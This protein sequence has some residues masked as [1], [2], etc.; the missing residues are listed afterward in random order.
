MN[1][2]KTAKLEN[3]DR[4]QELNPEATLKRAGFKENMTLCDIGAGT[5]I[6]SFP[7]A[8]MS[9]NDIYALEASDS[10]LELL[11]ERKTESKVENLQIRKVDSPVLPLADSICDMALLV[12]VLHEIEDKPMM[13]EEIRRVL[14][15]KGKLL[16]IEF[17]KRS[18][19]MGPPV[20]HRIAQ[21]DAA[22]LSGEKG[23]ATV[24][25]FSLG[26][27]FYGIVLE[28][29]KEGSMKELQYSITIQAPREKV[30]ATLWEDESFRDWAGLIDEGTYMEGPME[31]GKEVRFISSVNGYG[32]TSL[33]DELRLYE[34]IS[35]RHS[36]D[37]K[38]RGQQER[39]KEWTGGRESYSLTEKD[40]TTLLTVKTDV[41]Q[42]LI[43]IFNIRLPLALDRIRT[44]A[45]SRNR[46]SFK[47]A[48]MQ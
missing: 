12:T 36:T 11:Q 48:P 2:H 22:E 4:V 47:I 23:F 31:E 26:G 32:V 44:L 9:S 19:P 25:E 35:F 6:F 42:E 18:T 41:P 21:E 17:H 27:N 45:E 46:A 1:K 38:E 28:K 24:D 3:P 33:I 8:Q 10:M 20:G 5:G 40:G 7:A 39:E 16:I 43:E 15:A 13:L 37:T 30:W 29:D 14:K 34:F